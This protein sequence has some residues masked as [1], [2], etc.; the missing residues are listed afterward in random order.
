MT[1]SSHNDECES[2]WSNDAMDASQQKIITERFYSKHKSIMV[3]QAYAQGTMRLMM[4]KMISTINIGCDSQL[5]Q[6]D[7]IVVRGDMNAKV[8][9]DYTNRDDIMR[10][11]CIGVMNDNGQRLCDSAVQMD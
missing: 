5:Y 10:R 7:M 3:I 6:E 4:T 9:C 8:G 1:R 2:K 11:H